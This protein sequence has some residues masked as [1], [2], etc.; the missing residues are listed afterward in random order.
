MEEIYCEECNARF[1]D[2]C[3]HVDALPTG[4]DRWEGIDGHAY[5]GDKRYPSSAYH[6]T[7]KLQVPTGTQLDPEAWY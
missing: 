1:R 7:D 3:R 2:Q 5:I 6:D 4:S